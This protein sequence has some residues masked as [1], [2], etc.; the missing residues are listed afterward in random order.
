MPA[1]G[2][3]PN[4]NALTATDQ[5][6]CL[7]CGQRLAEPRVEFRSALGLQPAAAAVSGRTGR[8]DQRTP[9]VTV[10]AIAAVLLALGVGI[11]IGR[12]NGTTSAPKAQVVTVNGG[13]PTAAAST[14]PT[15][16]AQP[17]ASI[18]DDW[19]A[20]KSAYTVEVGALDKSGAQAA[21]VAKAKSDAASKGATAVGALDGDAHGGTPTGKYVI[22]SG[23]FASKKQAQAALAKL[24]KSFP[25][26]LVLHVTPKGSASSKSGGG[27]NSGG[28]AA[29]NAG[30]AQA[31][32]LQGLSGSA[33][34][35]A[36]NKLPTQV[37]TGGV[38]PPK[39]NKKAGG[40]TSAT[41]IGC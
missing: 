22:Y 23:Q 32:N 35:K 14:T 4:C 30:T 19:S 16:S 12:G 29:T 27:S 15:G 36:A 40:G 34:V 5:R 24:K 38:P 1:A 31:A 17:V 18:S 33:Y 2:H 3:C 9:V 39:D 13:A 20:S 28:S 41:C 10:S 26:A 37:G 11:V 21:D 6:Y 8:W 25:G 7:N